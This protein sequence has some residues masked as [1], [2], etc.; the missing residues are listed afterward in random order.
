MLMN[1]MA[2][3]TPI[4]DW[5]RDHRVHHKYSETDA[6]PHNAKRGFFFSHCGWIMCK[7]HPAV[8]Q[9]AKNIDISDLE[10]DPLVQFQK[11]IYLPMMFL[12]WGLL[13][14]IIPWYCWEETLVAAI[15][16]SV[17]LRWAYVLNIT[18][19]VNSFAHIWG[20]KVI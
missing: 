4:Y 7:K 15:F 11:K 13:P 17:F 12:L 18:W 19:A 1:C 20:S 16:I 6:D 5:C 3:Q 10:K 14:S 8:K 2:G 9:Y